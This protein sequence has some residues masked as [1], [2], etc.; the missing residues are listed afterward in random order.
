MCLTWEKLNDK[1]R[2][3][4]LEGNI[5]RKAKDWTKDD[6]YYSCYTIK[7]PHLH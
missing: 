2:T 3:W 5:L 6:S 1:I 7:I 4:K